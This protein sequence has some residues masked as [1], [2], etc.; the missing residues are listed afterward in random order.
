MKEVSSVLRIAVCDDRQGELETLCSYIA[1]Y[2]DIHQLQAEVTAFSHP[3]KLLGA[4]EMQS[5]HLYLLDIVMPM[6]NGLELGKV[7]R[8]R[9]SEAQIIYVTTEPQFALQA[10]AANPIN[11][12]IKPVQKQQLFDT[13]ALAVAKADF[14]QEQTIA[15]KTV[16]NLRVVKL[17]DITC[18]EYRNHAVTFHLACGEKIC[19]RTIRERFSEYSAPLLNDAHFV[20]CHMSFVVNM[21]KVEYFAKESFTLFGGQVVPIASRQYPAVRDAYMDYL[22]AKVGH[23]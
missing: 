2:L 22:M 19:S 3:D 10:Y 16:D 11:Y 12:L 15:V 9:D 1:A 5:F 21:R 23:R 8:R 14:A 13:L 18:C 4:L 7:I 20:Q 17:A 6:V